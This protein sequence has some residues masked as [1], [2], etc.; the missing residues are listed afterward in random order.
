[1]SAMSFVFLY[2]QTHEMRVKACRHRK[3]ARGMGAAAAAVA[4]G[5][6]RRRRT[7]AVASNA[8]QRVIGQTRKMPSILDIPNF[9]LR[10]LAEHP[11][12]VDW[13]ETARHVRCTRPA[14]AAIMVQLLL[15]GELEEFVHNPTNTW[16]AVLPRRTSQALA[17]AGSFEEYVGTL[18]EQHGLVL[19]GELPGEDAPPFSCAHLELDAIRDIIRANLIEVCFCLCVCL[20]ASL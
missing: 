20:C 1:M 17:S 14:L 10:Y 15:M 6:G 18:V 13:T 11:E 2:S 8:T 3:C 4:D 7:G 9:T 5:G 12:G 16:M 19:G